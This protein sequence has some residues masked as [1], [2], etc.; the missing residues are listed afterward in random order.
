MLLPIEMLKTALAVIIC[1]AHRR[2]HEIQYVT[3]IVFYNS[4]FSL[5]L[6]L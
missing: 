5:D 2:Q 4:P 1:L 3:L 6:S